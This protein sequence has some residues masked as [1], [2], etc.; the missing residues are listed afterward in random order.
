[1]LGGG[2]L[3]TYWT[4]ISSLGN[5]YLGGRSVRS[6]WLEVVASQASKIMKLRFTIR[7]LFWLTLVV[8]M[9]KVAGLIW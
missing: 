8:A 5:L 3:D 9:I 7:D 6:L 4:L 2:A 1:V